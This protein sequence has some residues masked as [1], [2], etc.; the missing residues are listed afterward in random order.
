MLVPLSAECGNTLN[1]SGGGGVDRVC[2][3]LLDILLHIVYLLFLYIKKGERKKLQDLAS[4]CIYLE[5][6]DKR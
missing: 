4:M 5:N 2:I 3:Y 1:G 6:P